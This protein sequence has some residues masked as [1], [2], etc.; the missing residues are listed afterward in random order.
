MNFSSPEHKKAPSSLSLYKGVF[1]ISILLSYHG[2][3]VAFINS[4]YLERF[5]SP[6]V[7]SILY[8]ISALVSVVCFIYFSHL[9]RILGN[10]Y[11]LLFI[12]SI[13]VFGLLL[14]AFT[15]SVFLVVLGFFLFLVANPLL[16]LSVDV[17]AE[18]IAG[19]D[20]SKTGSMRGL[21]LTLINLAAASA[22]L[23]LTILVGDHQE[24][25]A[26]AYMFSAFCG[27][28]FLLISS[29]YFLHFK[30]PIYQHYTFTSTVRNVVSSTTLFPVF[31]GQFLL[32]VFFSWALIY[33]PLYLITEQNF[34]WGE[35][36]IIVGVA[37]MAYVLL[38][39]PIGYISDRWLGEKEFMIAGFL[40]LTTATLSISFIPVLG[41]VGWSI[42][43]FYSRIGAALVETTTESYFFKHTTGGDSSY[44]S[45][46]R[47][48]RPISVACGSLLGTFA[49]LLLPF[50]YIFIVLAIVLSFGIYTSFLL[51]D[52]R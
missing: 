16:Y 27:V 15:P 51:I 50:S 42:L 44:I 25:L 34:T 7:I 17:F 6:T 23:T 24:L 11:T 47:M 37:I 5:T 13:E 22:P 21:L 30:D 19:D 46:F 1:L 2:L 41:V 35:V 26:R 48:L 9:L 29:Y 49:L 36:G 3:L 33:F 43:M 40:I 38:Q 32:Q 10:F 28:L 39:Y 45:L 18:T 14:L 31:I 12:G 4:S 20:E 52:T 8:S